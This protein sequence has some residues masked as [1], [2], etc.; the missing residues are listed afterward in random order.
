MKFLFFAFSFL[1]MVKGFS[2][3]QFLLIGTYDSPKSEGIYVYEF[4]RLNGSAK[5][6]SYVKTSNPSYIAIS[7]NK[8]YVYAVNENAD[9][10]GKG[11]TVTSFFFDKKMGILTKINT[12]S[13][14]GNDPCYITID[15]SGKWIF[16]ANYSS[17]NFAVLP[18]NKNGALLQA[19]R[20]VQQ[21]GKSID[22]ARQNSPHI[23]T[24]FLSKNN[25]LLYPQLAKLSCRYLGIPAGAA[26]AERVWN[27]AGQIQ[28]DSRH[29]LLPQRVAEHT[30][31]KHNL[32]YLKYYIGKKAKQ[33]AK[34]SK[35]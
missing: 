17:G 27:Y 26:P 31:M 7:T 13:S 16:T 30:F 8:K 19:T 23:H 3:N 14:E 1:S 11:G 18:V 24:T 22:T 35:K 4:N 34:Q 25:K 32:Q 9:K 6:V 28:T 12:Q 20:T 2:Q 29:R 15:N 10:N 5:K 33:L 21:K